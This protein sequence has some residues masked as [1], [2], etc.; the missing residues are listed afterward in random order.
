M[1]II[2]LDFCGQNGGVMGVSSV[3]GAFDRNDYV[4]E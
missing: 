1:G 3:N 2:I 4:H